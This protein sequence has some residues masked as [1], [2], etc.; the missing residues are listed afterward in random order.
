MTWNFLY[1]P[2]YQP[3]THISSPAS[4]SGLDMGVSGW[5]Q[6]Q[7]G[8]GHVIIS[9]IKSYF[10]Q[11]DTFQN[12]GTKLNKLKRNIWLKCILM[13]NKNFHSNV[14]VLG[15]FYKHFLTTL[16]RS[17]FFDIFLKPDT[18]K[19]Y[20]QFEQKT[21]LLR[22]YFRNLSVQRSCLQY[23]SQCL[24]KVNVKYAVNRLWHEIFHIVPSISPRPISVLQ[25]RS[26][27]D[28]RVSRW[29]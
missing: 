24:E 16:Y 20:L 27:F 1:R 2:W 23:K 4:L 6:G 13:L 10:N 29:Y 22:N 8:K 14:D 5:Y 11:I 15:R 18:K 9:C 19:K 21:T 12:I 25:L 3:S 7:Y 28:M 17:T 26:R